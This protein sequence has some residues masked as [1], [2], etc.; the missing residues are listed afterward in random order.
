MSALNDL[1]IRILIGAK[2]NTG[3]AVKSSKAGITSI[4]TQLKS[5][6]SVAT[7]FLD[8]RLFAGWAQDSIQ[9]S[10]AYKGLTGRLRQ[11]TSDTGQLAQVQDYL[12][13]LS[14]RTQTA[15]AGT[16]TLYTRTSE[17]LKKYADG[18]QKAAQLTEVVNLSFKAQS[19]SA[20]LVSSTVR[21]LTQSIGGGVVQW[22]DFGQVADANLLLA[23]IA[24]K[25]LGFDGITSLK[26]AMSAGKVSGIQLTDA[27]IAGFDEVKAA[28]DKMPVSVQG[29]FT[30][31]NNALLKYVG[32]S[33]GAGNATRTLTSSI[34]LLASNIDPL[35][36]A[37]ILLAEIYAAKIVSG[38]LAS[39]KA[40]IDNA[41]ATQKA[42]LAAQFETEAQERALIVK[43]QLLGIQAKLSET[44][45][46]SAQATK[47]ETAAILEKQLALQAQLQLET[48]E[49]A[50]KVRLAESRVA[51]AQ[52]ALVDARQ[53]RAGA[54]SLVEAK[55][56]LASAEIRLNGAKSQAVIYDGELSA[57]TQK[58]TLAQEK[59]TLATKNATNALAQYKTASTNASASSVA[60][61][62]SMDK[63]TISTGK[64]DKAMTGLNAAM[65]LLLAFEMGKTL[66][67]W[68]TH[69]EA[70][71]VAGSYL[72]ETAA[73]INTGFE[74]MLSDTSLSQRFEQIKQIHADFDEL[75]TAD[76]G[77]ALKHAKQQ[78]AAEAQKAK[79]TEEAAERQK[80]AYEKI[81][82]ATA[83]LT[84]LIDAQAKRQAENLKQQLDD[85]LQALEDTQKSEREKQQARFDLMLEFAEKETELQKTTTDEKLR[86]IDN[87][88][89]D[90]LEKTKDN[91]TRL[92]QV[93][94]EK[95]QA[96]LSVYTGLAKFYGE[97]VNRLRG[98]YADEINAAQQSRNALANLAI[99]HEKN[100]FNI[101]LG[102]LNKR[103]KLFEQE[104]RF[105]QLVAEASQ[106]IAKGQQGDQDKINQLLADSRSLHGQISRAAGDGSKALLE[107]KK[108]E[109]TLYDAQKTVLENNATAHEENAGRAKTALQKTKIELQQIQTTINQITEKL[110]QDLA[111]FIEI[112]TSSL[113]TA[114][115]IINEL[116]R[117]ATKV[118]TIVTRNAPQEAQNGGPIHGFNEGGFAPRSGKL[119]GFG[120]GDKVKALLEAGEFIIR[121]EAVQKLGLGFMQRV[122]A[123]KSPEQPIKRAFGGAVQA[124]R[125]DKEKEQGQGQQQLPQIVTSTAL[126]SKQ[127]APEKAQGA[128]SAGLSK[129]ELI[130]ELKGLAGVLKLVYASYAS[131]YKKVE[132]SRNINTGLVGNLAAADALQRDKF[133]YESLND[134]VKEII[135]AFKSL[136]YRSSFTTL[137]DQ[138][139]RFKPFG[140]VN[141]RPIKFATG[142]LVPG[143]GNKDS[144]PA[145]LTPGEYVLK[146]S[147]VNT[148]GSDFIAMLN[149]GIA[150]AA[151][152][153]SSSRSAGGE[154]SSGQKIDISLNI[155]GAKATG[156]FNN[157]SNTQTFLDEI[158]QAGMVSS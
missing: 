133:Q 53:Q 51:S 137:V 61:S 114:R 107:A 40:T 43:N 148:L 74:A 25:N 15:L 105:N 123:G 16:V 45:L 144:V 8:F 33:V 10:D 49:I 78:A 83:E 31:L 50:L 22:E 146:K 39:A 55:N 17:A 141:D 151:K 120:G 100:L 13:N 64:M 1:A 108:R 24:A 28:A 14:Q 34:Q 103:D 84:A 138:N 47:A 110:G 12:F 69:F 4:S 11:V 139:G 122:N 101:K 124:T 90:E 136:G 112:D 5:L 109:N 58:V 96:K 67:E 88:Y 95:R 6:Q 102:G 19:L 145:M 20:D 111:L 98:V 93:E 87:E 38:L 157:D 35:I 77:S 119:S 37:A 72:A 54:L 143:S 94:T 134:R 158:R 2:D 23:N 56:Q 99:S 26:N 18:Q 59:H 121:K 128:S 81:K 118:I 41:T 27:L 150:P 104:K 86:L 57:A 115:S 125:R 80:I 9:L 126:D 79:A 71:R 75:R 154:S 113:S 7:R 129:L 106:E 52:A 117:P 66:G 140:F 130:K 147:A 36:Q 152:F 68:L 131:N 3:P 156:A 89:Q 92:A 91:K 149:N 42:A 82:T 155:G 135:E 63:G 48:S 116:T 30:T 62:T 29:A 44:A 153:A 127:T 97:E 142:G 132:K 85:S 73:L 60:L 65:N 21:Q 70:V 46:N 76:T 32:E